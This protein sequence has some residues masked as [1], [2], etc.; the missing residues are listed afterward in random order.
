[1]REF[2]H[3]TPLSPWGGGEGGGGTPISKGEVDAPDA[4]NAQED[5]ALTSPH[6]PHE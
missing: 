4:S 2:I 3:H 6:T 1:M 5:V